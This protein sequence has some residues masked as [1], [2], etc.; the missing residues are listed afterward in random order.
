MSITTTAPREDEHGERWRQW[1][2]SNARSSRRAA[3]Q[4]RIVLAGV[5]TVAAAWLALQLLSSP[6]W[7]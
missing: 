1:Q 2:L 5:L 6:A 3:T 4:A 7:S